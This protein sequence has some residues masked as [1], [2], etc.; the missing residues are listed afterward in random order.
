MANT[1]QGFGI[2]RRQNR[3]NYVTKKIYDDTKKQ[4]VRIAT[5]VNTIQKNSKPR[6]RSRVNNSEKYNNIIIIQ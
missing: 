4:Y 3:A 1:E 6:Q 5:M 2:S